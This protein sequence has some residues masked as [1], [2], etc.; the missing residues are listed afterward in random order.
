MPGTSPGMTEERGD[1]AEALGN[2]WRY[3][4]TYLASEFSPVLRHPPSH[5]WQRC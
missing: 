4:D 5:L 2:A 1:I 3:F